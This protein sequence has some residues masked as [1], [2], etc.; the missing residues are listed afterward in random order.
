MND[1]KCTQR[2]QKCTDMNRLSP[3]P[4]H[5]HEQKLNL[6]PTGVNWRYQVGG[7]T[8]RDNIT[9]T[10]RNVIRLIFSDIP[11]EN[12]SCIHENTFGHLDP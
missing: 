6:H 11:R 8:N 9:N 4:I 3:L 2:K 7:I 5:E 10:I 12:N 1:V